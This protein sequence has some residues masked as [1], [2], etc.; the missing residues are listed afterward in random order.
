MDFVGAG[1]FAK[2]GGPWWARSGSIERGVWA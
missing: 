1:E 2:R